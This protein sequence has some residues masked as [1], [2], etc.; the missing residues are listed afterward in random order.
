MEGETGQWIDCL[1]ERPEEA[2]L[3]ERQSWSYRAPRGHRLATGQIRD[4]CR[5]ARLS[6]RPTCQ[7]PSVNVDLREIAKHGAVGE[8]Y[9]KL[10]WI[11]YPI[12]FGID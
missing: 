1:R 12:F 3:D 11:F 5:S 4:A 8:P 9:R 10:S 6:E 7:E 2:S